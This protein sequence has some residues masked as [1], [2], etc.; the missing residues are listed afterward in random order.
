PSLISLE[1][2]DAKLYGLFRAGSDNAANAG[3]YIDSANSGNY[4]EG[5]TIS[6]NRA[7]LT[8]TASGA[9]QYTVKGTTYA[10]EASADS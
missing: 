5:N 8:F 7:E 4:Y 1:A 9:G 10:P 6:A 3:G 2:E